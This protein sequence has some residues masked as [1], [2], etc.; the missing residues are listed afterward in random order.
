MCL[1]LIF[2]SADLCAQEASRTVQVMGTP[3][4]INEARL[5]TRKAGWTRTSDHLYWTSDGGMNWSNVTPAL[6]PHEVISAV[7]FLDAARGWVL[8]SHAGDAGEE[9][10]L[11]TTKP[12]GRVG[13]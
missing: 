13:Q 11:P 3:E 9:F 4:T 10:E 1:L 8:L 2:F 6:R 12:Q 7:F 5:V